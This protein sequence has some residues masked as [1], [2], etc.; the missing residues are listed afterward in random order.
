MINVEN[1]GIRRSHCPRDALPRVEISRHTFCK[2]VMQAARANEFKMVVK[3]WVL[4]RSL[5]V[6]VLKTL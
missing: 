3:R 1:V 5:L 2:N 6:A 4:S